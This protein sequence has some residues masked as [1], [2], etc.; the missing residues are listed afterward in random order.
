MPPKPT[1]AHPASKWNFFL[2]LLLL[3]VLGEHRSVGVQAQ[4]DLLV[5]QRVLLLD[6]RAASDGLTLGGVERAL[7]FRAVDETGEIGLGDDV[8]GEEEVA[9]VGG[10]LGGGAVDLVQSL[11][12]GGGPDDEAA[13]VTTGGELEEVEGGDGAG[14]D[15]GDVAEAL[16]ELLA[17][18]GG[19]VDDERAAALAVAATTELT[20]TGAELLGG[21][22]LVQVRSGTDGLEDSQGAGG[23]GTSTGLEDGG[24]DDE[25]NLRD[26]HDLVT[27][28]QEKRSGSGGSEGRD[29][30]VTP[31]S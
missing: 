14:L 23:L 22:D 29:G 15:T 10:G 4:H 6:S 19:V 27:A 26:A 31:L 11:E 28:G 25:G 12:G 9:L 7:D 2:L 24:V 5:A 3:S 16:D 1:S 20:L 18:D 21:L 8:G 17:V 13:E 30:S